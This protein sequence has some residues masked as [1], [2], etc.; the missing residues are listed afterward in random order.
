MGPDGPTEGT[1]MLNA[2][3]TRLP[4]HRRHLRLHQLPRRRRARPRPGHP[5]R[6]DGHGRDAPSGRPSGWPSSRATR[7]SSTRSRRP[8][9]ARC[10]RTRSSGR[11]FAFRRRLRD[12]GQASTLRL[13]RLHPDPDLDLKFVA[14]H[15]QV[16][17]QRIAGREELVGP[18]RH[19]GPPAA[20]ERRR[21]GD[22]RHRRLRALHRRLRRGHG[23]RRPGGAGLHRRT[24][25]RTSTRRGHGLGPRPRT[26]PGTRSRPDRASS[27]RRSDA[28]F[29]SIA[30]TSRRPP[31][32]VW[33]L[34]DVAGPPAAVAAG[35]T[36]ST[37]RR[38]AAGAA[39]ARPTT[40]CTART[41]SSRRSSTGDRSST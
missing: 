40:A 41:R 4:G 21:R 19:R 8:S 29:A 10:S 11:Y 33:E 6:P 18:R 24:T 30:S 26:R 27:S 20:Q 25:R 22:A 16:A 39:S 12:I 2:A 14:H 32:I 38:P 17:R 15:G 34:P 3:R 5:G 37:R 36:A 28:I 31:A 13:Q 35:V 7:P 23:P 9:T 1:P